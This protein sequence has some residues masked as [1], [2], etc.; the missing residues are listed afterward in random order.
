[1]SFPALETSIAS[2]QPIELFDFRRSAVHWRYAGADRDVTL[3][4]A[5]YA[6][7]PWSTGGYTSAG[8]PTQETLTVTGPLAAD[9]ADQFAV[10]AP[11]DPVYLTIYR[12]HAGDTD[13]EAWWVGQVTA[14]ARKPDHLEFTGESIVTA[15]TAQGLRI[16]WQK[17]CPFAIYDG[18]CTLDPAAFAFTATVTGV[19]GQTLTAAEFADPGK[20]PAGRL[21]GGFVSWNAGD[22]L[23]ERRAIVAHAGDTI[24]LINASAG[25]TVGTVVTAH[26]GCDQTL[27]TCH[28]VFDNLDNYGGV[29]GLP[30]VNPF[31][32]S[33]FI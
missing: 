1:M 31:S 29:P 14:V 7:G 9:V 25:I 30:D 10:I 24:T 8:D 5:T 33:P 17:S 22:G 32:Q 13:P 11:S 3:T 20:T 27:A 21:A 26:L 6:A 18:G 16:G 2:G 23:T 19:T 12:L 15:Q 28:D 4:G